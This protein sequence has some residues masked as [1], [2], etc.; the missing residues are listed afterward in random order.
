MSKRLDFYLDNITEDWTCLKVIGFYRTKI[1]RK[2]LKEVLSSIHKDLRDIANSNPR[3]DAT[4]KK[5]AREI[6]DNWKRELGL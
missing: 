2:G 5:K 3:F 6:L 1:K 4:K